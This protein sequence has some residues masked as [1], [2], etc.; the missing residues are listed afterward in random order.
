LMGLDVL[1]N[2][3]FERDWHREFKTIHINV[4]R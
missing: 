3:V 1:W 4:Q 2:T